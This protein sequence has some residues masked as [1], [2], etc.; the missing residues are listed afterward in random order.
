V[1]NKNGSTP[2]HVAAKKGFA[3]II[4]L[5]VTYGSDVNR[6]DVFGFNASWWA[7]ENN[8]EKV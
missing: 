7:F 6:R 8:F 4:E 2:L 1:Q 5:L 3:E